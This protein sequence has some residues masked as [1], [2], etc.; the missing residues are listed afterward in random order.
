M[1][2]YTAEGNLDF[3]GLT[4]LIFR[5]LKAA[6]GDD[7][8]TFCEAFPNGTDPENV[9]T[10]VITYSL[11]DMRP[12][13]MGNRG[14]TREIKPRLRGEYRTP[15]NEADGMPPITAVYGQTM[16]CLIQFDCWEENN[17]KAGKLAKQFRDFMRTYTGYMMQKGVQQIIFDHQDN[18]TDYIFRDNAVARKL[19]FKVR[20]ED[21][22]LV[23][24]DVIEKVTASVEAS[25]SLDDDS[26]NSHIDFKL[27]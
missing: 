5:L 7:W 8:G 16:D 24:S 13:V 14:E 19:V 18:R 11:I 23:P 20:L 26:I 10:P 12:G 2:R 1:D 9:R 21:Q 4:D 27:P 3:D 22:Y 6:W 17:A 25:Y 15:L